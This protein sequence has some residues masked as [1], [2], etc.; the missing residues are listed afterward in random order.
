MMERKRSIGALAAL[1]LII[2]SAALLCAAPADDNHRYGKNYFPNVPLIT[3][4]GKV[5]HFYDDLLKGKIVAIDLIY[6]HCEFSCPLE[7]ARMAQVQRILGDKVGKGIFFYSISIDPKRDTPAELKAY[8]KKYHAGPGWLFLTGKKSDIDLVSKKL[9]LYA[10]PSINQDGHT[11]YLMLGDE[12]NGQWMQNSAVDNPRFLAITMQTFMDHGKGGKAAG[13][14]YAD[15]RPLNMNSGE[16]VFITHCTACHTIGH[17]DKVGPD[18]Q[19]VAAQ[20]DPKW[21]RRIIAEPDKLIASR[22]P[23]AMALFKKYNRIQMPNLNL[24]G[25]DLKAIVDYL[26]QPSA[27]TVNKTSKPASTKPTT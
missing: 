22:D 13:Q 16:Y 4:D 12:P 1:L 14:D 9:G 19:G 26:S 11:T 23:L 5:V 15:A 25:D 17:G 27:S 2:S 20:R 8:A 7:T 3:Q 18:L 24:G 21:F 10:D 6:T